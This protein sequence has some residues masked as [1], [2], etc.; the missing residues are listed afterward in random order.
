MPAVVF[1]DQFARADAP[2]TW[3]SPW[4]EGSVQ[5]A[6]IE[7][8]GEAG[9]S[10]LN[11]IDSNAD[12]HVSMIA[13]MPT[14]AL[15]DFTVDIIN[16]TA[17]GN[18]NQWHYLCWLSSGNANPANAGRPDTAWYLRS[19]IRTGSSQHTLYRRINNSEVS[20]IG[21]TTYGTIPLQ[22]LRIRVRMDAANHIQVKLWNPANAE[23]GTWSIDHT[24]GGAVITDPGVLQLVTRKYHGANEV[25]YWDLDNVEFTDLE[26]DDTGPT[27]RIKAYDGGQFVQATPKVW[28]GGQ[29][30][31]GALKAYDGGAWI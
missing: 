21:G 10:R 25:F 8:I 30:V 17:D 12:D 28:D 24:E 26:K 15:C 5:E 22:D 11:D 16:R 27:S 2:G 13:D 31:E 14:V 9:R 20:I 6:T 23:P 18:S 1:S 7:T 19:D 4:I 29:W 3:G